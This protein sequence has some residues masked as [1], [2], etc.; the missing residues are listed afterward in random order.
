MPA[1]SF[2]NIA[3][4]ANERLVTKRRILSFCHLRTIFTLMVSQV[5]HRFAE[6]G[7][8]HPFVKAIIEISFL[9]IA[10][11]SAHPNI[12]A[13]SSV[14]VQTRTLRTFFKR[15]PYLK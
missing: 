15:I 10:E 9:F 2:P 13:P 12:M 3:C 6:H 1:K 14:L 4:L 7:V 8:V 11:F 5:R